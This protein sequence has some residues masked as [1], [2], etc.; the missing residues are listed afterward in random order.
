MEETVEKAKQSLWFVMSDLAEAHRR[1]NEC[2]RP[3]GQSLGDKTLIMVLADVL[4]DTRR[5]Q[6]KLANLS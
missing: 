6:S 4:E 5:L 3:E 2:V 1:A